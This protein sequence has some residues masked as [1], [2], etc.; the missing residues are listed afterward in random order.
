MVST[1]GCWDRDLNSECHVVSW[2]VRIRALSTV[3]SSTA[4]IGRHTNAHLLVYVSFIGMHTSLFAVAGFA[5]LYKGNFAKG[6]FPQLFRVK[7]L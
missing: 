5:F 2:R 3:F 6:I 7:T 1:L 4:H